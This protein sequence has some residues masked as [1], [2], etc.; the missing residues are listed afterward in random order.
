MIV[1]C[2]VQIELHGIW[3]PYALPFRRTTTSTFTQFSCAQYHKLHPIDK[4]YI[5]HVSQFH[6]ELN[7]CVLSVLPF[8]HHFNIRFHCLLAYKDNILSNVF[9]I[10][11]DF[12]LFSDKNSIYWL[13]QQSFHRTLTLAIKALSWCRCCENRL[14]T[15]L[16]ASGMC[17]SALKVSM[18]VLRAKSAVARGIITVVSDP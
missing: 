8:C 5:S 3:A 12:P 11:C 10:V 16:S 13:K 17:C 7:F 9:M 4:K 15:F 14:R 6:I 18:V 1:I 2:R